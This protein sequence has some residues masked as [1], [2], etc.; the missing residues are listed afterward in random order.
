MSIVYY[1]LL[2]PLEVELAAGGR[3]DVVTEVGWQL[4]ATWRDTIEAV[5]GQV[6]LG[7]PVSDCFTPFQS[8]TPDQVEQWVIDALGDEQVEHYK[9]Q[10]ASRLE[11]Q[12]HPTTATLPPPWV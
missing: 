4:V 5:Y 8:L 6:P 1:W 10:L 12:L 3:A 2:G 9:T 11:Q 7:P